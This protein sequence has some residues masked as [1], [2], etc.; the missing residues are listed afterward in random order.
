[1]QTDDE[2]LYESPI[3]VSHQSLN[4]KQE[5]SAATGSSSDQ[6][7]KDFSVVVTYQWLCL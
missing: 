2:E 5:S 6:V 1:M 3:V 7:A 4:K